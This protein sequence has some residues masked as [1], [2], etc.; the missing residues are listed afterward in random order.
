MPYMHLWNQPMLIALRGLFSACFISN[1]VLSRLESIL[2]KAERVKTHFC[3]TVL[4]SLVP[5]RMSFKGQRLAYVHISKSGETGGRGNFPHLLHQIV[6]FTISDALLQ[7]RTIENIC[8]H[9]KC[10]ESDVVANTTMQN[11]ELSLRWPTSVTAK[12]TFSRQNLLS[13]GKTYFLTSKLGYQTVIRRNYHDKS[14]L[15]SRIKDLNLND[16]NLN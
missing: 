4:H 14:L 11:S 12:H 15:D 9:S 1:F 16:L 6:C 10:I 8:S 13:H 3:N 5:I 7:K 2:V